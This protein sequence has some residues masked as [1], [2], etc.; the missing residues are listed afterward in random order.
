MLDL[1]GLPGLYTM[2]PELVAVACSTT[3]LYFG[4]GSWRTKNN[5]WLS[6]ISAAGFREAQENNNLV[7]GHERHPY[8]FVKW[9]AACLCQVTRSRTSSAAIRTSPSL[10]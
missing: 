2:P 6:D 10:T 7:E 8:K 5:Y 3:Y 9:C 1:V 4:L